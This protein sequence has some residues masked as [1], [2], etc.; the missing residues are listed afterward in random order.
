MNGGTKNRVKSTN[1]LEGWGA[2][3]GVP[4]GPTKRRR[5]T[6]S[7]PCTKWNTVIGWSV[8]TVKHC[9]LG[10]ETAA[11]LTQMPDCLVM[12]V[13]NKRGRGATGIVQVANK[14]VTSN[15]DL[16]YQKLDWVHRHFLR[17]TSG[18][19]K[20]AWSM[21]VSLSQNQSE[22]SYFICWTTGINY[23]AFSL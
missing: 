15:R 3:G 2:I 10:S 6:T 1:G 12:H 20:V 5:R 7:L 22:D 21:S 19:S 11:S 18:V 14:K 13:T 23:S 17:M 9:F 4:T 8:Y 16:W